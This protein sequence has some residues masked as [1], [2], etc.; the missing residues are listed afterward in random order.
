MSGM[1]GP[2]TL[3]I[4]SVGGAL[5]G[6]YLYSGRFEVMPII[7]AV[8]GWQLGNWLYMKWMSPGLMNLQNPPGGFYN[9]GFTPFGPWY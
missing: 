8:L 7:V 3:S 4:G 5:A 2:I 1:L 9:L 6:W